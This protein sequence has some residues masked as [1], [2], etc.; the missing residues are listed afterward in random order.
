MLKLGKINDIWIVVKPN[1]GITKVLVSDFLA[2]GLPTYNIVFRWCCQEAVWFMTLMKQAKIWQ[3]ECCLDVAKPNFGA[4][5]ILVSNF[6]TLGLPSC[7][8]GFYW[9]DQFFVGIIKYW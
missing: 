9:C 1:F 8:I 5:K 2:I 3:K 7:D 4:T 6:L